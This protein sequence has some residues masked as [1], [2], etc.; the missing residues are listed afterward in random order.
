[1]QLQQLM[2]LPQRRSCGNGWT[3]QQT[4]NTCCCTHAW[5]RQLA[6]ALPLQMAMCSSGSRPTAAFGAM[7]QDK[8]NIMCVT[9][10]AVA[11]HALRVRLGLFWCLRSAVDGV[12]LLH[13]ALCRMLQC[14]GCLALPCL[15]ICMNHIS[16]S[17]IPSN[18]HA[19]CCLQACC[20]PYCAGQ[21]AGSI[22]RGACCC[23]P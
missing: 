17:L 12:L 15:Y 18:L 6:G 23:C 4:R 10:G 16:C 2:W 20:R 7:K 5:R 3:R 9:A 1:M 14:L 22:R 11:A 8:G 21:A 19:H 13:A